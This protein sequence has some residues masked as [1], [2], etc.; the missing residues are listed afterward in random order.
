MENNNRKPRFRFNIWW[1][2]GIFA[3]IILIAIMAITI[4]HFTT[5]SDYATHDY[6]FYRSVLTKILSNTT[7]G[8]AFKSVEHNPYQNLMKFT[9]GIDASDAEFFKNLGVPESAIKSGEYVFTLNVTTIQIQQW[10]LLNQLTAAAFTYKN[11]EGKEFGRLFTTPYPTPSLSS[12]IW[13]VMSSLLP[14]MAMIGIA[15][16]I[17]KAMMRNMWDP[18]T[19]DNTVAQRIKTDKKFSDIA[20]NEE[21]KEEVWELVDYLKNPKKYAVAGARIPKGILLG[22]PTGTGKTLIAKATAGEANVPFFFISS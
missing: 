2:L 5:S 14:I 22:G 15:Y 17:V 19:K 1:L 20:G 7:D 21:V 12:K 6:N 10:N 11:K 13:S 9:L 8:T 18:F 3:A 4:K 16:F